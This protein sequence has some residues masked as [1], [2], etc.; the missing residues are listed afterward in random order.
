[1]KTDVMLPI[2]SSIAHNAVTVN[3]TVAR[4]CSVLCD[5]EH[6]DLPIRTPNATATVPRD[7]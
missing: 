2:L 7:P 3:A 4:L 6:D 1:M 5:T